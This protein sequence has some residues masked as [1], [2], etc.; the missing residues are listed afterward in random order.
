MDHQKRHEHSDKQWNLVAI[1]WRRRILYKMIVTQRYSVTSFPNCDVV[2]TTLL[3]C[4]YTICVKIYKTFTI[5]WFY[6]NYIFSSFLSLKLFVFDQLHY[7]FNMDTKIII[8]S[9]V[10]ALMSSTEAT[11]L[12]RSPGRKC[13][14]WFKLKIINSFQKFYYNIEL[15]Y[16]IIYKLLYII[17][18]YIQLL[19]RR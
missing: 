19:I 10:L 7:H 17:L 4:V 15:I 16:C 5:F 14:I 3:N 13:C 9:C 2:R 8:L 12:R 11:R 18:L 6:N 1:R